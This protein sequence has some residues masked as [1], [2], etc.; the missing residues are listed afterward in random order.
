MAVVFSFY[1]DTTSIAY[2]RP[3]RKNTKDKNMGEGKEKRRCK[4]L[5]KCKELSINSTGWKDEW[6]DKGMRKRRRSRRRRGEK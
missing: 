3:F 6:R 1:G 2:C 4:S 5:R